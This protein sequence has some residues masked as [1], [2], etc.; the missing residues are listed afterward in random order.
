M[1]HEQSHVPQ[2]LAPFTRPA[3]LAA[4]A[5]VLVHAAGVWGYPSLWWGDNGRWLHELDQVAHGAVFYRD[6]YWA[7]PP[8][9][10]WLLGGITRIIGA[11][12]VQVWTLTTLIAVGIA[13]A[14]GAVTARLVAG[15]LGVLVAATGMV[16]GA[17]YSQQSSAPLA[18]GMYTPAVPVAT[19]CLMVQLLAF[20]RDWERPT[21][22]GAVAVGVLGAL[23]FLAK[24]DVWFACAWITL[25]AGVFTI[26]G[27]E[28]RVARVLAAGGSFAVVA[29]IGVG[30]LAAQHGVAALRDIFTGFGH[31]AEFSGV[32]LPDASQ[33]T[34]ELATFG[35][36]MAL[37]AVLAWAS[38][39]WRGPRVLWVAVLGVVICGAAMSI[40]LW[41][42]ER[43]GRH[44]MEHGAPRLPTLF[45]GALQPVEGSAA[46]RVRK[47]FGVLRLQML[48][49]LIP[50]FVPLSV[51]GLLFVRRATVSDRRLWNLVTI[52]L[53]ACLALRA[54]RMVSFTEW[55]VLMVE[56]PVY[57]AAA[58]LL[59]PTL[60]RPGVQ[61]FSLGCALLLLFAARMHWRF[62]YGLGSR[63]GVQATVETPRGSARLVPGLARDLAFI[64]HLA[65]HADPSG[66]RPILA[67][68]Y[69]GGLSYFSGRP[70][71]NPLTQGFRLSLLPTP[72]SAYRIAAAVKSRLLLV[73]NTSYVDGIPSARF[74]PWR[75]LPEMLPNPYQ[76][77]DRPL[78]DKLREGCREVT[79]PGERSAIFTMYDC[80]PAA[81]AP[82]IATDS[83]TPLR[84][85]A[86]A[87]P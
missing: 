71:V 74:A 52:L 11:D 47:A 17:V 86:R 32:N 8:L 4:L 54:R 22:G 70:S 33:I 7:F 29:G 5:V 43:I 16:L 80:A 85:G 78:F 68:G 73:D 45:E 39:A 19:L 56:L 40:W 77:V 24:H 41:Q 21:L 83:L 34:V 42:A 15:R 67:F 18:L 81:I 61:F 82:N 10:M 63:R 66:Q 1:T 62:G 72:D 50:L 6:I 26:P 64:R 79:L 28:G 12:L 84:T 51:L 48:R 75:W 9:A 30:V 49:H 65:D 27:R 53:V 44:M 76:R 13:L 14:Y 46:V 23:G 25:A 57:V 3:M 87:R 60:R 58:T 59:W 31:V 37:V 38:G 20:L 36:A 35:A 55:S 69:S 2:P